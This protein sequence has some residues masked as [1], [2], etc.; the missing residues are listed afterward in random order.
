MEPGDDQHTRLERAELARQLASALAKLPER[1]RHVL[2]LYY[3][4]EM[5]L[6]EVGAALGVSESRIS[7]LRTQAIARLRA[8]LRES[9]GTFTSGGVH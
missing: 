8:I 4:E 7:Q 9:S 2:S 3:E 5:T 6:A 1:E